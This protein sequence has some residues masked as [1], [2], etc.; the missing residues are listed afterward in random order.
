MEEARALAASEGIA[1]NQLITLAL[2]EKV[3]VLR[4]D[5]YFTQRADRAKVARARNVL[6]RAG[7][8]K[9]PLPG[10]EVPQATKRRVRTRA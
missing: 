6:K 1:L 3:S 4:T 7:V 10:D 5:E 2:A 8:G 9:P